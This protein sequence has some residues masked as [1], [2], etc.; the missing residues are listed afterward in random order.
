M[1]L[2]QF[3]RAAHKSSTKLR[4]K[5]KTTKKCRVISVRLPRYT[6]TSQT[7]WNHWMRAHWMRP[8]HRI[9]RCTLLLSFVDFV[10]GAWFS[11]E[12]ER[13]YFISWESIFLFG[14]LQSRIGPVSVL[15]LWVCIP[16]SCRC[17]CWFG[18]FAIQGRAG[19]CILCVFF[20]PGSRWSLYCLCVYVFAIQGHSGLCKHVFAIQGRLQSR[21][22][23]CF[24]ALQRRVVLVCIVF[25]F[26]WGRDGLVWVLLLHYVGQKC[27]REVLGMNLVE[28]RCRDC[29]AGCFGQGGRPLGRRA[30]IISSIRSDQGA[31]KPESLRLLGQAGFH[32]RRWGLY[33]RLPNVKRAVGLVG[34]DRL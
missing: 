4:D 2:P 27:C 25:V 14:V 31:F 8:C 11:D 18:V 9:L 7:H 32:L 12:S 33:A 5:K 10:L 19:L 22:A 16:G 3:R 34:D 29:W 26:L 28:K 13:D 20:N 17:L 15:L 1:F 6:N 21:V 24:C 30:A 23:W